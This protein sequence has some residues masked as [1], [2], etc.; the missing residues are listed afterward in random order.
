M[1]VF[2]FILPGGINKIIENYCHI[3]L[4]FEKELLHWFRVIT[5]LDDFW[6]YDKIYVCI[7]ERSIHNCGYKLKKDNRC[8]FLCYTYEE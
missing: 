1:Y 8:K 3:P 4:P 6:F 5:N 7:K 2:P